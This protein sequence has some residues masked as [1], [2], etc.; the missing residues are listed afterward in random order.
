MLILRYGG[1]LQI[2]QWAYVMVDETEQTNPVVIDMQENMQSMREAWPGLGSEERRRLFFL[3]PRIEAED[4]FLDMSPSEQAEML[5]DL[6][7]LQKRSWVRLLAPD[8]AADLIQQFP[9]D[10]REQCL[11]LLDNDTRTDVVALLTYAEDE[12][13]GLMNPRFVRLRPD[14][15]V[16][17]AVRYLRTQARKQVEHISYAY[18]INSDDT[19]LGT[20]SFR[21]LLL[22]PP[23]RL[24]SQVMETDLI[25]LPENLD[26]EEVSR[27][28]SQY[29]LKALPVVDDQGHIKGIVTLDDVVEVVQQEATEDIQKLGGMEA[30]DAPYFQITFFK[31]VKKRAGWLTILFLSEMLTA[32][33]MAYFEHEIEKAVVLA[34]FIPL[35]MSSGGNS[36]SQATTLIIRAMAL[37][38]VKLREWWRV[39]LREA[40][41]GLTLGAILGCIGIMR[42]LL[43]PTRDTLYGIHYGRIALT[44]GC[45]LIG[46]VGWGTLVGSMLPFLLKRLGFDPASASAPFVATLVDVTGIVIYFTVASLFLGGIL[47]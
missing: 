11:N 24:V 17:V 8:D 47:L 19:L 14:V 39:F 20:V 25:T 40:A 44:I 45:S 12:A 37:G 10:E 46:I 9:H 41:A 23:D 31:M 34:L 3:L 32:T 1:R 42:I 15:T 18:V 6:P 22:S 21:D 4:F 27:R 29:G 5:H 13:G 16:D 7:R 33:A 35:V 43:W 30:L 28:F 2:Q 38:E 36:G 26:Q